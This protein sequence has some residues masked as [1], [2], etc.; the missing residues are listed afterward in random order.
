MRMP[1]LQ[2]CVAACSNL[3]DHDVSSEV[4]N[5][6]ENDLVSYFVVSMAI[7]VRTIGH[8]SITNSG[9]PCR[10]QKQPDGQASTWTERS[11][12]PSK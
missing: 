9:G 12:E 7:D 2:A 3:Q 5:H 6:D 4:C 10:Q 1:H 8:A 11:S